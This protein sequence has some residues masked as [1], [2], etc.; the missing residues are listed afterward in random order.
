MAEEARV[1]E[2]THPV[3]PTPTPRLAALL[4]QTAAG[5]L[6]CPYCQDAL[7]ARVLDAERVQFRCPTCGFVEAPDRLEE[8]RR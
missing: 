1:E 8:G 4:R 2:R 5:H 3:R 6:A 7:Q